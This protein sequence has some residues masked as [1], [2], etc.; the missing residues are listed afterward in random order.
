MTCTVPEFYLTPCH[1]GG[2]SAPPDK[3]SPW[4]KWT[5]CSRT[6]GPGKKARTRTCKVAPDGTYVECTG[7]LLQI[8]DCNLRE[9][10]GIYYRYLLK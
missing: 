6:C 8:E 3:F 2:P 4:G 7:P 9:C 5:E 1:V 10:P